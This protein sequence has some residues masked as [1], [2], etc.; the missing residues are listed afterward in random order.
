MKKYTLFPLMLLCLALVLSACG[1]KPSPAPGAALS[2]SAYPA[3][4]QARTAYPASATAPSA[5][6]VTPETPAPAVPLPIPLSAIRMFPDGQ[7]WASNQTQT[8]LY[9]SADGGLTWKEVSPSAELAGANGGFYSFYLDGSSAWLSVG[10]MEKSTLL[11][12][13]DGGQ[14]W[15]STALDFP[16]GYLQFLNNSSGFMLSILDVGAGS[17]YVAI[18]RT[19]DGGQTWEQR[20]R[21][22]PGGENPSLPTGGLKNG[23]AFLDTNIGSVCGSEPIDNYTY[24]F[25]SVDGGALWYHQDIILP[26]GISGAMIECQPPTYFS[27]AEAVLP[28]KVFL[29]DGSPQTLFY[30]SIDGGESWSLLKGGLP[31]ANRFVFAGAQ[32]WWLLGDSGLFRSRDGGVNW[33]DLTSGLPAGFTP[34]NF[35]FTDANNGWMLLSPASNPNQDSSFL[36]RSRD[37][38]RT[39]EVLPAQIVN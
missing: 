35:D 3:G 12:S 39:W 1:P 13:S 37:G 17:E 20:F 14:T 4:P 18:Y 8:A 27:A 10:R 6:L 28:L 36:Y 31:P 30:H 22:E 34:L 2:P 23:L 16:A 24:L 32:D 15:R 38:G 33:E 29:P 25:R 7:G 19:A 21:H 5:A 9:H 26:V 11:H